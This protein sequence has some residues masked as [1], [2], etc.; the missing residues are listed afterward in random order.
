MVCVLEYLAAGEI[1]FYLPLSFK[2]RLAPRGLLLSRHT[3]VIWVSLAT[4][5]SVSWFGSS[6]AT[7][8]AVA[9]VCAGAVAWNFRMIWLT[10][11]V[12]DTESS[13]E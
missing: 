10:H 12:P 5:A 7:R 4:I 8:F 1:C 11:N 6:A 13:D 2:I 9:A 3:T